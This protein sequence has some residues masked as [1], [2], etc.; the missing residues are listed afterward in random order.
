MT[1]EDMRGQQER[2]TEDS[3]GIDID[4]DIAS[5]IDIDIDIG[6]GTDIADIDVGNVLDNNLTSTN[7]QRTTENR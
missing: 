6:T 4:V 1:T 3:I 5:D 7:D 2:T